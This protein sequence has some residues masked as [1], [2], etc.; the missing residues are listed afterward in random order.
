MTEVNETM[1]RQNSTP[2]KLSKTEKNERLFEIIQFLAT[3]EFTGYLKVNFT[4]GAIG[5]IEK[6]E[7]LALNKDSQME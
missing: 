6:L 1:E 5:R 7:E 4:Q 3:R 2:K